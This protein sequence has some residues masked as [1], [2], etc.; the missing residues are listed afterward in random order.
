MT[1][2]DNTL[3]QYLDRREVEL[4]E[5]ID[6]VHKTLIPLEAELADVRKAKAAISERHEPAAFRVWTQHTLRR[7]SLVEM[8]EKV[9]Q[10]RSL[11]DA[12]S[13][14]A[15]FT[16]IS[17]YAHLTQKQLVLKALT[18]HFPK[19]ATAN[20]LIEF[21]HNAWKRT[22][23]I[24]SSLSPQLSRLKVED[25]IGLRG[26]TWTLLAPGNDEA[27]SDEPQG[28]SKESSPEDVQS[29]WIGP[30]QGR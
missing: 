7:P 13:V 23:V 10:R 27:P 5:R 1:A 19:G 17:P 30:N 14:D 22:D 20:E 4:Q 11:N 21:F 26:K 6:G 3:A 28:A 12:A 29:S 8:A 2:D 9:M 16:E 24:R 18:E 15:E 25:K